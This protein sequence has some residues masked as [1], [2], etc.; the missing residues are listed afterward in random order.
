MWKR[1]NCFPLNY[2]NFSLLSPSNTPQVKLISFG[3]PLISLVV[4]TSQV[5]NP[6]GKFYSKLTFSQSSCK[7]KS[8]LLSYFLDCDGFSVLKHSSSTLTTPH[9]RSN[10]VNV[11]HRNWKQEVQYKRSQRPS[12]MRM[13]RRAITQL[14]HYS[15]SIA[16]RKIVLRCLPHFKGTEL[17]YGICKFSD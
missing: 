4:K 8:S 11:Q 6:R 3:Y 17:Y 1:L 5:Q 14:I 16:S 2:F 7:E 13:C 12:E 9:Q 15:G 10:I